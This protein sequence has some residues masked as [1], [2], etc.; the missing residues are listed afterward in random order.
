M[1]VALITPSDPKEWKHDMAGKETGDKTFQATPSAKSPSKSVTLS[2][3][4]VPDGSIVIAKMISFALLAS[5]PRK[6]TC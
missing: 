4:G 1:N 5:T 2:V 3:S 6:Y